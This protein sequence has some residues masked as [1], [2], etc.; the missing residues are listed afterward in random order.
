MKIY[1]EHLKNNKN[2]HYELLIFIQR[3]IKKFKFLYIYDCH[4]CQ[5]FIN[6][7]N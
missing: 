4:K 1:N 7:S 5:N 2:V 6:I 3:N